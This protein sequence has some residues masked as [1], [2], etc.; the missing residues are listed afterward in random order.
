MSDFYEKIWVPDI[1][2]ANDKNAFLHD[3]TE[4]NKMIKIFGNGDVLYGMR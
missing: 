3:V 4:K 2:V 1:F